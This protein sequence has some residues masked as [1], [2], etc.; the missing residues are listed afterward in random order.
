MSL[1]RRK[2]V[3]NP[4]IDI[5]TIGGNNP[6]YAISASRDSAENKNQPKLHSADTFGGNRS[7]WKSYDQFGRLNVTCSHAT[8][9]EK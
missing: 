6:P 7:V 5:N 2:P 4:L 3:V 1:T 8:A 9:I